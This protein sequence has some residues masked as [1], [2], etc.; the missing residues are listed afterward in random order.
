M[1][2]ALASVKINAPKLPLVANVIAAKTSDPEEI[3]KLLVA[4]VTG[5]VRWR[6]S[7]RYMKSEGIDTLVEIGYGKVLTGLTKRIEETIGGNC[8][9]TIEDLK[10]V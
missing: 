7:V 2:E 9:Q 8:I 6:E 4:Q 5:A 10:N 3:R 1:Q